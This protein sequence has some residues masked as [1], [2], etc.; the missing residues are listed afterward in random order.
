MIQREITTR[1]KSIVLWALGFA[2]MIIG[3]M[4]KFDAFGE[5]GTGGEQLNAFIRS[6]P[7]IMRIIYGMEGIDIGYF[8]GYFGLLM[9]Y[10][11]I[12]AAVHG[13]F[14]GSALI[15]QEFRERTADFL[16]VKPMSRDQILARKLLGGLLVILILEAFIAACNFYVFSQT[17]KLDLL[18]RTMTAIL[19]THLFYYALGFA[20]TVVLPR[21]KMGQ[22]A[23]LA[24]ILLSYLSISLSQLY[25]QEWLLNF[26][27][28]AWY[29]KHLYQ[30]SAGAL[31]A[32]AA[33]LAVL[34]L[35]LWGLA[36]VRFRRKDI[37]N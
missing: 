6:M 35:G 11:L 9:L 32:V 8:E 25:D 19:L 10:V 18:P 28:I 30:A 21:S 14:L 1:I 37:P 16:F 24:V 2:F 13:A 22:K 5:G 23:S 4:T 3:G 15:H 27:P 29:N 17:D 31:L 26:S 34:I 12:M 36:I 20:L 33:I 7:R